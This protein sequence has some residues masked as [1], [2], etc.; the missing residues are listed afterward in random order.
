MTPNIFQDLRNCPVPPQFPGRNRVVIQ[1]WYIVSATLF[2][3]SPHAFFGWRRFLL[4]IFG[5]KVG[6]GAKFRPSAVVTYPWNVVVGAHSYIGDD[7]VLYSLDSVHIG[8]HV[9]ISY[10][11]FL[12]TGTHDYTDANFPLVTKPIVVEDQSW[13]AADCFVSPGVKIGKGAVIGAR[14]T[15]TADV[16][17]GCIFVGSPA[18]QVAKRIPHDV[19]NLVDPCLEHGDAK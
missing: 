16:P 14:S 17:S 19:Q 15:V 18:R 10:R 5:A 7:T 11:T 1:V 12:C 2:R 13:L 8:S 4:R 9:S 3:L 6:V